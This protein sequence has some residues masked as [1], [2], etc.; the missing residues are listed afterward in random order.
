MKLGLGPRKCRAEL[1]FT[2]LPLLSLTTTPH[3]VPFDNSPNLPEET[4]SRWVLLLDLNQLSNY[5]RVR[6]IGSVDYVFAYSW[7]LRLQFYFTGH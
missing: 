5:D 2:G 3:S 1:Y 7:G 6:E 4:H